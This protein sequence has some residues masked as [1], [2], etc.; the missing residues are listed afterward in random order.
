MLRTAS[1]LQSRSASIA[2]TASSRAAH[3]PAQGSIAAFYMP[4]KST[5]IT[6]RRKQGQPGSCFL[7]HVDFY[8]LTWHGLALAIEGEVRLQHERAICMNECCENGVNW[9]GAYAMLVFSLS[10]A[11]LQLLAGVRDSSVCEGVSALSSCIWC[12]GAWISNMCP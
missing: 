11:S 5:A 12:A 3:R 9:Q 1:S 10:Q 7:H 6:P 8:Q 2:L 4:S